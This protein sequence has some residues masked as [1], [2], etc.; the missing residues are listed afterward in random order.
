MTAV[1]VQRCAPIAREPLSETDAAEL[2][3]SRP[4]ELEPT[5]A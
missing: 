3:P 4:S 2:A 1:T 5:P